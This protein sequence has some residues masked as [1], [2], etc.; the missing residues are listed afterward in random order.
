MFKRIQ[1]K[2][3]EMA[4]KEAKKQHSYPPAIGLNLVLMGIVTPLLILSFPL[5]IGEIAG[6]TG[7]MLLQIGI[8][9][10]CSLILVYYFSPRMTARRMQTVKRAIPAFYLII[11]LAGIFYISHIFLYGRVMLFPSLYALG[12]GLFWYAILTYV[13]RLTVQSN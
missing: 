11:L 3:D 8:I 9:A 1:Q 4:K 12:Y 7:I 13:R 6:L 2:L 5:F 10:A